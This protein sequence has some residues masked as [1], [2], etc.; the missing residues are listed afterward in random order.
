[1]TE[2]ERSRRERNIQEEGDGLHS[3][4]TR[5]PWSEACWLVWRCGRGFRTVRRV[6][7]GTIVDMRGRGSESGW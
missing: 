6:G 3:F 7:Q 5:L 2:S 4:Q 1:M